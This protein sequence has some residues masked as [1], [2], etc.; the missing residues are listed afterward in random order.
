MQNTCHRRCHFCWP[1]GLSH[2]NRQSHFS[3]RVLKVL[4]GHFKAAMVEEVSFSALRCI[5]RSNVIF[6]GRVPTFCLAET[7]HGLDE[8]HP[9][10]GDLLHSV[11]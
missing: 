10:Q 4:T 7:G 9:Q 11:C 6:L 2:E 8:M 1:S 3:L 5:G